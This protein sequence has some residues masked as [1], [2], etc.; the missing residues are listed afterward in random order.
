MQL[1]IAEKPSVAQSIAKVLGAGSRKNGY[2][3]GNG[4]IV[5]WCFGHLA[6]LADADDYDSRYSK[7]KMEHLPIIPSSFRFR[8]AQDKWEQFDV[9]K[10]LMGKDYVNCV[11]NACDAGREGELIFR[12]VYYLAECSKPMKRLWIS[13]MEDDAIRQLS[14]LLPKLFG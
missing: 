9:L 12:S 1:V 10:S 8:I 3:E 5:S 7:W 4:Y 6:G 14:T 2:L 13:S 11:I